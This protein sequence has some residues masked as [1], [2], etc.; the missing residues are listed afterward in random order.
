LKS[1]APVYN[2][3]RYNY[4]NFALPKLTAEWNLNRYFDVTAD[5]TPAEDIAGYDIDNF[6]ISSIVEPL[7]P[8]KG[9]NKMF[10]NMTIVSDRYK[11]QNQPRFYIGGE[12]DAYKY[13]VSPTVSD[14]NGYIIDCNPHIIYT[15]EIKTNKIVIKTEN[16]WASP[17]EFVVQITEDGTT[18]ATVA[19][20]PTVRPDGQIVLYWNGISWLS[21][22]PALQEAT[23]AIRGVRL[24]VTRLAGG[25]LRDG[26]PTQYFSKETCDDDTATEPTDGSLS[27]FSLIE[28]SARREVDLSD[29][30]ISVGDVQES[31]EVSMLTPVGTITSNSGSVTLWNADQLFSSDNPNS[32]FRKMMEPN[33]EMNLSW[34]YYLD[35]DVQNEVKQFKM[36][37]DNWG[38]LKNEELTVNLLDYSKYLREMIPPAL[39]YEN[40]TL[41]EIMYR[42][43]DS[44]GFS[45]YNIASHSDLVQYEIPVWYSTG[46]QS[47]WEV[48]D[49]L[50]VSTQTLFYFDSDGMLN[51]KTR[52]AAFDTTAEPVWTLRGSK[53]DEELP[54]IVNFEEVT[55]YEANTVKV[56]YRGA[57]WSKW[58]NGQPSMEVVWEPEGIIALRANHLLS[59]IPATGLVNVN[60]SP[61]DARIWP[62]EGLFNIEGEIFRYKG[63]VFVYYTGPTGSV[64]NIAVVTSAD[65]QRELITQTPNGH[66]HKNHL[67]GELVVVKRGVWNSRKAEHKAKPKD[68]EIRR[69]VNDTR[70]ISKR[71]YSFDAEEST[72]TLESAG[73]LKKAS[74]R[75][76]MTTG[77]ANQAG[78]YRQYGFR[79]WFNKGDAYTHQIAG[80]VFNNSGNKENGYHIELTP[81]EKVKGERGAEVRMYS[82]VNQTRNAQEVAV[83]RLQPKNED[84]DEVETGARARV[85][86][87]DKK[88][89]DKKKDKENN[90]DDKNKKKT[91]KRTAVTYKIWYDVDV[92][93]KKTGGGRDRIYVYVNGRK[94]LEQVVRTEDLNDDNTKFGLYIR[95]KTSASFEFLYA[96]RNHANL[97]EPLDDTSYLDKIRGGYFGTFADR[98][99]PY[100][101]NSA[102]GPKKTESSKRINNK[103]EFYFDEFGAIV[104][105]VREYEVGFTK[106]PILH[107]RLYFS[108]DWASICTEYRAN[109]FGCRFV[110]ANTSRVNSVVNGEE[111]YNNDGGGNYG[112]DHKLNVIGR[113]LVEDEE[114]SEIERKND[115]QIRSRGVIETQLDAVWIQTESAAT[116][117]ADWIL[118]TWGTGMDEARVT[119][120]GNPLLEI[121]DVVAVDYPDKNLNPAYAKYFVV[122]I[123]TSWENGI[124][125]ALTLRRLPA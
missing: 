85:K 40:I 102:T 119:V 15:E 107:S 89:K 101:W 120:Y 106:A 60:I 73:K 115:Q 23:R 93:V 117:I 39:M 14:V 58:N 66:R 43:C 104:H 52:E 96:I 72:I 79:V 125:T 87:D 50:A 65:Q 97:V 100:S 86:E 83:N 20:N 1:S 25:T 108:N 38:S 111:T 67:T 109:S 47:V 70:V 19:T 26:S 22:K 8:S 5:N 76:Y 84:S 78:D 51:V 48:L 90:D 21:T 33:V 53:Q 68:Y 46:E 45:D 62:Y 116:I 18:W 95:G 64:K 16:T 3:I 118:E 105:E 61:K 2:A 7:R 4:N 75:L 12:E 92:F 71:G 34:I 91:T 123:D 56:V 69:L 113:P 88:K 37:V 77:T 49:S 55:A 35:G 57:K 11:D 82:R 41:P 94:V 36:Y 124:S 59:N 6:P 81:T 42:L 80:L 103:P 29:R 122:G 17:S 63:K 28:I 32:E 10:T 9:A 114:E 44:V 98:E 54:D 99:L 74:D 13:W 31:G 30:L 110:V 112:V 121:G 24:S 27:R